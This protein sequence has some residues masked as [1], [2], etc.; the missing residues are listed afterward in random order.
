LVKTLGGLEDAPRFL[1]PDRGA[2]LR[3]PSVFSQ[4][5]ITRHFKVH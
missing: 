1:L 4:K 3:P 2:S 5:R